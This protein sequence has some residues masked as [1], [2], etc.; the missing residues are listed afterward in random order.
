[1]NFE[2][3]HR[4]QG[5]ELKEQLKALMSEASSVD[6]HL[7][8]RLDEINRWIKDIKP[9]SL[10]AKKFV[11]IFLRQV[12]EDAQVWLEIKAFPA[13][14][15][16][17]SF[18]EQMTPT[19]RSWYRELFPEWLKENDPKFYIW[20][21]KLM[22][23]EFNQADADRILSI[24]ENIRQRGGAVS[25]RYVADLSMATDFIVSHRQENPLCVQITSLSD[26]FSQK[27]SE[28]W[29]STLRAWGIGRGLFLS[30]NPGDSDSMAQTVNMA[31]YNSDN[32]RRG[33]YL[34]FSL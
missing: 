20:K 28:D 8:K 5:S 1:V 10:V 23:G 15:E 33:I 24:A 25:Q 18:F 34:K 22:G 32:L 31:L 21:Q 27:K 4:L 17:E 13:Q 2:R 30:Y 19:E 9:G 14:E 29:E 3:E 12:I 26:E 11:I 6:A 16:R 7:A